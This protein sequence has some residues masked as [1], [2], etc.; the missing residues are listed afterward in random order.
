M[1]SPTI[2]IL[3]ANYNKAKYIKEAIESVICQTFEDWELVIID[4]GSTDGS[5]KIISNCLNDS[6]IK[7][8]INE[9]NFGTIE[10][11][12]K[13]V[14][15]AASDIVCIVDSDD[16]LAKNALAEVNKIYLENPNCGVVYSQYY[17]CDDKLRPLHVG[18]SAKIPDGLSNLHINTVVALRSFRKSCYNKTDGYDENTKYAED[19]DIILKLEEVTKLFFLDKILYYYRVVHNSQTHNFINKNINRSST[20]LAKYNAYKRRLNLGIPNLSNDEVA[21]VLLVGILTSFLSLRFG[22]A[23]MYIKEIRKFAKSFFSKEFYKKCIFKI[24]KIF[25]LKIY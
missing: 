6:R 18:Y 11:Q 3:M 13:L 23:F 22:F 9:I 21:L 19:I 1:G 16:V 20:A 4:D 10:T 25:K 17:Y 15:V 12:K 14:S 5:I 24:I 7:L 8:I 2:S